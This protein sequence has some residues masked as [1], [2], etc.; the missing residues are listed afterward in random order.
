MKQHLPQ[1][2]EEDN[3]SSY[4]QIPENFLSEIVF[5]FN[6]RP[7]NRI[8]GHFG[9]FRIFRK[10]AKEFSEPSAKV[11]KVQEFWLNKSHPYHVECFLKCSLQKLYGDWNTRQWT[12]HCFLP[13]LKIRYF[14]I[15]PHDC[16]SPCCINVRLYILKEGRSES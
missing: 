5:P 9:N 7:R 15:L 12:R 2:L 1:S 11:P 14:R 8:F 10:I 13:P 4:T 6:F 16:V 3:L